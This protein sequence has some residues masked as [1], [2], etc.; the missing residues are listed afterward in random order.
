MGSSTLDQDLFWYCILE[1]G[2]WSFVYWSLE[3]AFCFLLLFSGDPPR[4]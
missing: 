2:V 3:F 1:F 4:D